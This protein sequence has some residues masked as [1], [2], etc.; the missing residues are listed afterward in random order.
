MDNDLFESL[1]PTT[2]TG[3]TTWVGVLE[4]IP[5]TVVHLKGNASHG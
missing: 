2:I 3:L 5:L 4:F 1:P